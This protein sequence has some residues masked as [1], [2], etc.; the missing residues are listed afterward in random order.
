M[1]TILCIDDNPSVLEIYKAL[2]ESEGYRILTAPDGPTGVALA[3]TNAVDAAVLDFNMLGMKGNQVAEALIKEQPNLPV[4]IWSGCPDEVPEP[5]KWYADALLHKGDG[6][7][8]LLS[9]VEKIVSAQGANKKPSGR[10][11]CRES[12]GPRCSRPLVGGSRALKS[13][14]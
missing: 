13:R 3:R 12:V 11:V 5:L 14:P 2:L 6:P 1:A 4:V 10:T 9:A 7:A 8:S